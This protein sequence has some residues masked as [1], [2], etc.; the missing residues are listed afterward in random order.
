MNPGYL[1]WLLMIITIILFVSGWKDF[2]LRG[3][4]SRV[5][6]LFCFVDHR[7]LLGHLATVRNFGCLGSCFVNYGDMHFVEAAGSAVS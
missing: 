5:I 6:L 3:I 4:T 7:E 1:S 2:L